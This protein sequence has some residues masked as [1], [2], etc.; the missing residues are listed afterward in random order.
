MKNKTE[1]KKKTGSDEELLESIEAGLDSRIGRGAIEFA[2]VRLRH[3][4]LAAFATARALLAALRA[5]EGGGWTVRAGLTAIL[6][7]EA[8]RGS[9]LIWAVLTKAYLP[10]L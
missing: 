8:Q 7:L 2:A 3:P 1:T 9:Q 6:L 4:V 10:M 5:E